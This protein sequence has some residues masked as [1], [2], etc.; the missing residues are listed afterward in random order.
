MRQSLLVELMGFLL[1]VGCATGCGTAEEDPRNANVNDDAPGADP[2]VASHQRML[3]ELADI[4]ARADE[5]NHWQGAAAARRAEERLDALPETADP[6][7]RWTRLLEVAEHELRLGEEEQAIEHFA[8]AYELLRILGERLEPAQR[9]RTVFR[10]GVA[11]L[12]LGEVRNCARGHVAESCLLPLRGGGIHADQ[13]GSRRAL[14]FLQEAARLAPPTSPLR[15][16]ATWLVNIAAMTL[17]EYPGGVPPEHA[18]PPEVFASPEPF[19]RFE[20]VAPAAGIHDMDLF[21]GV[22]IDDFDGDERLDLVVTSFDL[23]AESRYYRGD[24]AGGFTLRTSEAGLDGLWGG[25][26]LVQADYDNDGDLDLYVQRGAWN[27]IAGRHPRSLLR[28]DGHGT[29]TDV[30]FAVGLGEVHYPTQTAAWGDYDLDGDV[31]LYVGNEHGDGRSRFGARGEEGAAAFEAPCQL[32]RNDGGT[33]TDVA[34]AAG[35]E[36]RGFVKGVVWGDYDNDRFPD[37]YVSVLGG[38]NRLFH[39]QGDGTFADRAPALGVTQPIQSFPVWFFDYD[40]DG[41]LDL[42]AAS[43]RGAEDSV[44]LVA[45]SALG[46]EVPYELPRL[47]RGDGRGG[48]TDVSREQGLDRLHLAMGANFGDADGDG[49]LDFYLGTGYPDYEG[50]VPNVLYRNREGRGFVDVTWSAGVGHLQKGHAVAFADYDEDGDLDLYAQMGGAF[51]GDGAADVLLRNPGG[52][53]RFVT[54]RLQGTRSNRAAIGA[55]LRL[56]VIDEGGGVRAIHREVTSG[57]SFGASP[58]RQTIGLGPARRLARLEVFWP[59]SDTR[60]VFEEVALDRAYRIVEGEPALAPL[61][62]PQP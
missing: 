36:V 49:W 1:V 14:G 23:A 26:N 4:R 15:L 8:A 45:A 3:R 18:L 40:N 12:R 21:G 42:F 61:R 53:G 6:L 35:V 51:P 50:L 60:Q 48:F 55:K 20:N 44:A 59:A 30:T 47:Y 58:L 33:F 52:G 56:E 13:E 22:V 37:L 10:L 54:L 43:Y 62:P 7:E 29:F 5:E 32:F 34:A 16:K 24:G 27:Y 46:L 9:F 28:N 57:G 2:L 31:D 11:W 17:G 39:N 19:R 38:P 25:L 41:A